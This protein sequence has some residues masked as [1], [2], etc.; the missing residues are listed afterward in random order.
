VICDCTGD[1]PTTYQDRLLVGITNDRDK[2][3]VQTACPEC[4]ATKD[5]VITISVVVEERET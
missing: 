4:G 3:T 1:T 2:V 5:F